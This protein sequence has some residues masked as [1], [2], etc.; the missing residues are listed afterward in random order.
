MVN[1]LDFWIEGKSP[2]ETKDLLASTA[3]AIQGNLT[4][5]QALS[6]MVDIEAYKTFKDLFSLVDGIDGALTIREYQGY[7]LDFLTNNPYKF[8][9]IKLAMDFWIAMGQYIA[10]VTGP[11]LGVPA[12]VLHD[13]F[14][15]LDMKSIK[16]NEAGVF[17]VLGS[18]GF[19][20]VKFVK[21]PD[22]WHY[23]LSGNASFIATRCVKYV[24]I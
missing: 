21:D 7:L 17:T 8:G 10:N 6:K 4:L 16:V 14:N 20:S 15:M 2:S 24:N 1:A 22:I 23:Y 12:P 18:N 11:A 3:N 5:D 19:D 13:G 9:K